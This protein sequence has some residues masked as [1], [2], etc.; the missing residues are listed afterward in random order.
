MANDTGFS[1]APLIKEEAVLYELLYSVEL[2]HCGHYSQQ[3]SGRT[4]ELLVDGVSY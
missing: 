1:S 4:K 2:L 3:V